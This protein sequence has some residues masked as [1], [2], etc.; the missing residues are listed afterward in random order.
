MGLKEQLEDVL[1]GPVKTAEEAEAVQEA[2]SLLAAYLRVE[3][4]AQRLLGERSSWG[5]ESGDAGKSLAGV[6][7]HEAARR[8]LE[9][10]GTPLHAR[11][12]GARIKA[13]GW[14]HPRSQA[15]RPE[16]IVFQLAARLPKHP[17][18]FRRVGPN[19]FALTKWETEPPAGNRPRPRLGSFSGPGLAIGREIGESEEHITGVGAA[20]RSS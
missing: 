10:A 4:R 11:E 20:W 18:T 1:A 2:A 9:E 14:T 3:S 6:T 5:L 19:T 16:Q 12:L 15:A 8:V 13:R 17:D 7:L